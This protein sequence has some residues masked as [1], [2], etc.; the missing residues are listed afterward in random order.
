VV[1]TDIQDEFDF[2]SIYTEQYFHGGQ[3]DGYNN[4]KGSESVLHS[5]FKRDVDFLSNYT[6]KGSKLLE[7]GSAYGFF[8]DV[9]RHNLM[10]IGL[11]LLKMLLLFQKI[12]GTLFMKVY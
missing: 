1:F 12:V 9:A 6:K 8:L 7:L 11:K 2:T 4:Y 10:S 3:K 5:K